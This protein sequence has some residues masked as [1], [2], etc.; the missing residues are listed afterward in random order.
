MKKWLVTC[1]GVALAAVVAVPAGGDGLAIQETFSGSTV[2]SPSSWTASTS[3]FYEPCLTALSFGSSVAL[4]SGSLGGCP[5]DGGNAAGSGALQLTTYGGQ[6]SLVA[7]SVPQ[8]AAS[9][10]SVTFDLAEWGG[11]GAA[12]GTTFFVK[13]ATTPSVVGANGGALGY[14]N[15]GGHPGVPGALF[16]VGF[17]AY[18]NFSGANATCSGG[19]VHSPGVQTSGAIVV[20]GPDTSATLNGTEGY[21]YLGGTSAGAASYGG[22]SRLGAA[23]EVRVVMD[24]PL[25][26]HPM[27]SV[28]YGTSTSL[29]ATPTLVVPEPTAISAATPIVF[30]FSAGTGLYYNFN[31]VWNVSSGQSV[32]PSGLVANSVG[33]VLSASWNPTPGALSYTC[34]LLY[35]SN[36]PSS[37]TVRTASPHCTFNPIDAATTYGVR[38]VANYSYGASLPVSVFATPQKSMI[39]CVRDGHV[40]HV[41]AY[42]PRCPAGWRVR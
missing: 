7:S 26:A 5:L 2:T 14:E 19:D 16:G 10:L 8:S 22:S 38:V 20:R 6:A 24:S 23:H 31:E 3:V 9:G 37:F 39:T 42:A 18:G 32:T 15:G 25:V 11:Y 13:S 30:G 41:T 4:S 1:A 28:Y 40:R 21:C 29:P 33:G 12:D 35:G 36:A 34:T 27:I 17:D